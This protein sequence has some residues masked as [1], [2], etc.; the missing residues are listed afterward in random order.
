MKTNKSEA[1]VVLYKSETCA[2]CNSLMKIW[3]GITA[4]LKKINPRIRIEVVTAIDNGGRF[5][6][7]LYPKDLLKFGA[8]FPM[9]LLIPGRSWDAARTSGSPL[10]GVHGMNA[11]VEGSRVKYAHKYDIRKPSEFGRWLKDTLE[12]DS[13]KRA[14]I[15][16]TVHN[17]P[18]AVPASRFDIPTVDTSMESVCSMKIIT[19]PR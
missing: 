8:W 16:P 19:R 4:E 3:D 5:D 6:E 14:E 15:L 13:F 10:D 2:Y 17:A 7:T 18:A 1:V 9:I 12:S 11:S